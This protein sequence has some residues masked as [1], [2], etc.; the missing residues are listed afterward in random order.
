[1]VYEKRVLF[2]ASDGPDGL[3]LYTSEDQA[4]VDYAGD[5]NALYLEA[6]VNGAYVCLGPFL[7]VIRVALEEALGVEV[8]VEPPQT[9]R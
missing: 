4:A 3:K 6:S 5:E 7:K 9:A 1:M 2:E 8:T